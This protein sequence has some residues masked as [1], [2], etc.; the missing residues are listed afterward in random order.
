M[1]REGIM[2]GQGCHRGGSW[3]QVKL[4]LEQRRRNCPLELEHRHGCMVGVGLR[5]WMGF[6]LEVS[7]L[8]PSSEGNTFPLRSGRG[9]KVLKKTGG[10]QE[11]CQAAK[12]TLLRLEALVL[13]C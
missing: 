7:A 1:Q 9:M 10:S 12:P 6:F 11:V 4:A 5:E 13:S 3:A 2:N 8:I